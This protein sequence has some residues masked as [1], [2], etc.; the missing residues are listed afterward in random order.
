MKRGLRNVALGLALVGVGALTGRVLAS[1]VP[2]TSPLTWSGVVIDEA[3]KPYPKAVPVSVAF[4]DGQSATTAACT[5]STVQAQAGTGYFEVVLP[6][7]CAK[8]VHESNDLWS[9]MVVG[10]NQTVLPRSRVGAVPYALEAAVASDAAGKLKESIDKVEA[11][12]AALPAPRIVDA[13]GVQLGI[14]FDRFEPPGTGSGYWLIDVITSTGHIVALTH[15]GAVGPVSVDYIHF[16][17][18]G[19]QGPAY[20]LVNDSKIA[21]S[22]AARAVYHGPTKKFHVANVPSY[23]GNAVG[24]AQTK[25]LSSSKTKIGPAGVCEASTSNNLLVIEGT[26]VDPSAVGMPDTVKPPLSIVVK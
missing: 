19:C 9:E 22:D 2:G 21:R 12:A 18:A 10:D 5:S 11:M 17:E 14:M 16:V 1:G 8:A 20:R 25:T 7:A 13:N 26:M 3:G 4:Y 24:N 23:A 6:A 15:S